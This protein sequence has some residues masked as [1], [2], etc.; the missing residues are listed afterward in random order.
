MED[1]PGFSD[2]LAAVAEGSDCR[3]ALI[4]GAAADVAL[5]EALGS[6]KAAARMQ[7]SRPRKA[8]ITIPQIRKFRDRVYSYAVLFDA[9]T[10]SFQQGDPE[11]GKTL[12]VTLRKHLREL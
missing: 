9:F 4:R 10:R 8:S 5:S 3:D 1:F 6:A 7:Q 11:Y 12:Y 2:V